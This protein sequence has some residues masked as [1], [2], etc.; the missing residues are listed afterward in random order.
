METG[1]IAGVR[2]NFNRYTISCNG[3]DGSARSARN[4]F[5]FASPL[6]AKIDISI[7][8]QIKK[9]FSKKT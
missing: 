4:I 1:L 2:R 7:K 8:N 5:N 3:H 6:I 9:K